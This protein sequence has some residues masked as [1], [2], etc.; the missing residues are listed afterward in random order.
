M[1]YLR[2]EFESNCCVDRDVSTNTKPDK[3]SQDQKGVV[4]IRR[5]EANSKDGRE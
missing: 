1:A 5:A 3:G 2:N 4:V